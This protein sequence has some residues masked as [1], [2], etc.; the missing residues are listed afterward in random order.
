MPSTIDPLHAFTAGA[1]TAGDRRPV[2]LVSTRFDITIEAGLATVVTSRVFHNA[3]DQSIEATITFPVPVQAVMFGLEARI[4][5][6]LLKAQARRREAAR[7]TYEAAVEQG[8]AAVLHEEVLRGVHMLSVTHIAPG[9]AIEVTATWAITL[10][11]VADQARLRVPLTVGD[12]YGR[13]GLPDSDDLLTGG[14][15]QMGDLSVRCATGQ[16][17]LAGA[18]LVEGHA[19]IA[20]NAPIDLAVTGHALHPLNGRAADGRDVTLTITP[21]AAGE[22]ALDVAV[23]VDRSG[24]MADIC[25]SDGTQTKHQAVLSGLNAIVRALRRDDVIDLWQFDG[26]LEHVAQVRSGARLSLG[27]PRGGTEIGAALAGAIAGSRARDILLITDGQSHALDVQALARMGRR[28]SVLLIGEDSLEAQV[29]HLAALTGGDILIASGR[30]IALVLASVV[31]ALRVPFEA[32]LA[33]NGDLARVRVV[34]GNALLEAVWTPGEAVAQAP[35]VAALAA[36]MALPVL[37][38]ERAAALAQAEGLV[39]HLT[40]LVLVDEAGSVQEGIPATRKI[41]LPAPAAAAPASAL[42]LGEDAFL[43]RPALRRMSHTLCETTIRLGFLGNSIDWD[44][45]PDAL[46]AGD[47]SS[48]DMRTERL[49]LDAAADADVQSEATRRKLLPIVLIVALLAWSASDK[50]RAASR[51]A[52]AILKRGVDAR[53]RQIAMQF[54][55]MPPESSIKF[56]ASTLQKL[57]RFL[58][59]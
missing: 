38:A 6:R 36:G 47:L 44:E 26:R 16:V 46:V 24:S 2:P 35:A 23:L 27:N 5:G 21:L 30:D 56:P 22:A 39:T 48:L 3:E 37:D 59:N 17:V 41:A 55:I 15:V 34:R 20:L 7:E 29:G 33:V 42:Y 32:P 45:A 52:K 51:I 13:S 58:G 8:K 40:S 49:L 54:K 57:R 25:D 50:S 4:D 9:A 12:I 53:L 31:G 18:T 28:I 14:P 11:F 43:Q 19:R 10:A 1:F